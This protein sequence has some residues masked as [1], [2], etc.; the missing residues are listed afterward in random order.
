MNF[1]LE[2][3]LLKCVVP[4]NIDTPPRKGLEIWKTKKFK[5]NV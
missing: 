4:E 2:F 5:K 3:M 1:D